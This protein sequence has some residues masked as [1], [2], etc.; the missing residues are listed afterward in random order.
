MSVNFSWITAMRM[1]LAMTPLGASAVP[2]T[3]ALKEMESTVIVSLNLFLG[4][5]MKKKKSLAYTYITWNTVLAYIDISCLSLYQG[6]EV[7]RL[8]A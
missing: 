2:A 3:L 5:S 7:V 6:T 1:L 4:K 8:S